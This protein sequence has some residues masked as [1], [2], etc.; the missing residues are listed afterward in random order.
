MT[1]CK[2]AQPQPLDAHDEP[3]LAMTATAVVPG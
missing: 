3:G 1:Q 2:D